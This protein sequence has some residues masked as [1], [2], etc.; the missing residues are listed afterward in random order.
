LSRF[1]D[2]N[3]LVYAFLDVEKR[4]RALEVLAQGGVISAQVLSEFTHVAHKKRRRSWP[5]IEAALGVIRDWF[6]DIVPITSATH[7][8]AVA[9]AR[10]HSLAIYDAL[11]LAAAIEA[12]CETLYSEDFQH[13]RRFGDLTIVNPFL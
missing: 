11:I 6:H 1:F 9:L 12:G 8:A 2:T 7:A 13:G 5:D 4:G 10:D 3:V